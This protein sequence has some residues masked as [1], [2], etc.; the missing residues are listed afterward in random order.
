[1]TLTNSEFI[2]GGVASTYRMNVIRES[3]YYDTD[4]QTEDIGLSMKV[5]IKRKYST[6]NYLWV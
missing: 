2:I 5:N 4:T 3:G 1:M 6:E